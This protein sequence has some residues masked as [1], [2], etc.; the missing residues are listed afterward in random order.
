MGNEDPRA[1]L[2]DCL[3][4][5]ADNKPAEAVLARLRALEPLLRED[6][7]V[8]ARFLRARAIATNRLGFAG[9]ALGDLH[10]ARRLLEGGDHA[11]GACRGLPRDCDGVFLA[12]RKPRVGARAACASS[13]RRAMTASPLRSH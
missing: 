7:V 5:L 4:D 8:R 12:R 6:S 13:P 2:A 9:E 1:A 11:R 3:A 10:E